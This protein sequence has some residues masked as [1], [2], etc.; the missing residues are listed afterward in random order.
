MT[1][2]NTKLEDP[3]TMS[4]LLIDRTRFVYG[5][6]NINSAKLASKGGIIK[7]FYE[8]FLIIGHDQVLIHNYVTFMFI[9]NEIK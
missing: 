3:W 6:T 2:H 8:I 4:S 5:P 9:K 1:N 7:W